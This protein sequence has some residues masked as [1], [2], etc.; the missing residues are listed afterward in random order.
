M[1]TG[2][3]TL[4]IRAFWKITGSGNPFSIS[5]IPM[6]YPRRRLLDLAT[7]SRTLASMEGPQWARVEDTSILCSPP[8]A[9]LDGNLAF[10]VNFKLN[11]G[12]RHNFTRN[13]WEQAYDQHDAGLLMI[14]WV[15]LARN[16]PLLSKPVKSDKFK[17]R[18]IFF[19][20]R[21]PELP[22]RVWSTVATEFETVLYPKSETEAQDML[23]N[24]TRT[25]EVPAKELGS[26]THELSARVKARWGRH[27]F[28][29]RGTASGKTGNVKVEVE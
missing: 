17:R 28:T 13:L 16:R 10:T 1:V 15:D 20:T 9:K 7:S 21:N 22:Y 6:G 8:K 12:I 23:F 4:T 14:Y 3:L 18:A 19:W 11:G 2:Y 25:F 5:A 26:G 29:E 27:V 24:V